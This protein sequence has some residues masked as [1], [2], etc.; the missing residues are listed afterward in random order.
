MI[1]AIDPGPVQSALIFWDGAQV[2]ETAIEPNDNIIEAVRAMDPATPLVIEKIQCYG[3]AV[4][5]DVFES[6]WWT[7]RFT[8]AH[9]NKHTFRI[10]RGDVKM[11]LCRSMKAKDPNIRRALID[12]FGDVGTKKNP[13][14][15][16]GVS[17]HLWAALAVAV[18]W[19]DMN[20]RGWQRG[21]QR[22]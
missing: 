1:L 12:R 14:P 15:L 21:E 4:G 11:H 9:G 17:S 19:H 13:G 22:P 8:E 2:G 5:E 6:V 18:T 10:G 20:V 7:G 16:R 3:M